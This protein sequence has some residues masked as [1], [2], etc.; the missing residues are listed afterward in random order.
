MNT[1]LKVLVW[2]ITE[3][4][5]TFFGLFK[6]YGIKEQRHRRWFIPSLFIYVLIELNWIEL[7]FN[8]I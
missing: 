6:K 2:R 1:F 3:Y 4:C 8:L 7:N 5:Y